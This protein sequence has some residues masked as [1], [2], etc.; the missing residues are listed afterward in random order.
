[1]TAPLALYRLATRLAG[2][3]LPLWLGRRARV[4]KEDPARLGERFGKASRPR[5][6]GPLIWLHGAS[7]GE[8]AVIRALIPL[9]TGRGRANILVTTQTLTSARLWADDPAVIHQFAPSDTPAA[10]QRFIDYWRPDF[11][12]FVESEIWPNL[13][14]TVERAQIP[15]ALVNAR[16]NAD[17]LS[18]WA[19]RPATAREV[20]GAFG[21][22]LAADT[23][24]QSALA[25][26]LD[27]D[28]ILTGNLKSA[29]VP[30]VDSEAAQTLR[31]AFGRTPVICFASAH[32]EERSV[33]DT[34]ADTP[35]I[36]VPRH[37]D[38]FELPGTPRRSTGALPPPGQPFYLFDTIGEMGTAIA[39]SD[40]VIMGGSFAEGLK[41]HNPM[42]ALSLGKPVIS[43]AHVESFRDIYSRIQ[44]AS[45]TGPVSTVSTQ[46]AALNS[47]W[48]P[49][50]EALR[51][52]LSQSRE[53]VT[54]A[55]APL[56]DRVFP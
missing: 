48:T 22:I 23:A 19:R 43:G 14:S 16:M 4:G 8:S 11:A 20:F 1:M 5:P 33:L 40:A 46:E 42:E 52:D 13:L 34:W 9:I 31:N 24:T 54:E 45:G 56:L 3:L 35:L 49:E 25:D 27:R 47:R 32:P 10:T 15:A 53:R 21:A 17:S 28:I 12:L 6:D 55:L 26:L 29:A 36:I 18:R 2:P 7:V 30:A 38:R 50:L 41:G 51:D 44:E 39:A 37:P